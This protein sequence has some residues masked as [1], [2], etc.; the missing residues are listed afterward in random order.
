MHYQ[1]TNESITNYIDT[2]KLPEAR[3][4]CLVLKKS[5]RLPRQ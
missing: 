2:V 1:E 5:L 4:G 3:E